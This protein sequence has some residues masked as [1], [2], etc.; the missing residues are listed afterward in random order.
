MDSRVQ[1]RLDTIHST[2]YWR[3]HV[4]PTVYESNRISS[5][6]ELRKITEECMVTL[7]GWN[8]PH[9][10]IEET[11]N[12]DHWIESGA[13]FRQI[14]EYWRFYQYRNREGYFY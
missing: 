9:L 4:R 3:I 1:K 14:V 5:L 6:P 13:K 8:F 10:D 12:G 2:G 11:I 7:R